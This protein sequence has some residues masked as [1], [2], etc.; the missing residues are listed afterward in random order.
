MIVKGRSGNPPCWAFTATR[1]TAV[2][3]P[4]RPTWCAATT[5]PGFVPYIYGHDDLRALMQA[6]DCYQRRRCRLSLLMNPHSQK[7][8]AE[9]WAVNPL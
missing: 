1:F 9:L 2:T 8:E 3:S 4:P 7:Y 5:P 6:T